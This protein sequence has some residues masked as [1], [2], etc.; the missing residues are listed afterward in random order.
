[1]L[2][3]TM[4]GMDQKDSFCVH[5]LLLDEARGD[6]TGAV[7]GQGDIDLACLVGTVHRSHSKLIV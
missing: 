2:C 7:L 6:S 4:V 3:D 5:I 1:M